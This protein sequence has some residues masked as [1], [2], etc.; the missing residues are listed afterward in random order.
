MNNCRNTLCVFTA[1]LFL[2]GCTKP[3]VTSEAGSKEPSKP[4]ASFVNKVWRVTKSSTA[5]DTLYVFLS[6]GTL[7]ITSPHGK[8]AIGS[9]THTDNA[10]TMIEDGIPYKADILKLEEREFGIRIHNPGE[11]VEI[12]FGPAEGMQLSK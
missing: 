8:P 11:P 3:A 10:L 5:Q 1:L 7:V 12:T 9:W 4:G 6:D 2:S